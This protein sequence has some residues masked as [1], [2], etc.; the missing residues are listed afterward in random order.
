[1]LRI[2][3]STLNYTNGELANV[4]TTII[5]IIMIV[6]LMII[7]IIMITIIIAADLHFDVETT[8]RGLANH[9]ARRM[10]HAAG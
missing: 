10:E 9:C 5:V 7:T 2:F 6:I 4:I 8:R 1:M 3:I